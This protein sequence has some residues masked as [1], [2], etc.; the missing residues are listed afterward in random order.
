MSML[1]KEIGPKT[2]ISIDK[3]IDGFDWSNARENVSDAIDYH[4]GNDRYHVKVR[5]AEMFA[6]EIVKGEDEKGEPK[7]FQRRTKQ[8]Q[9]VAIENDLFEVVVRGISGKITGLIAS[10]AENSELKYTKNGAE[11][12]EAT[13]DIAAARQAAS[14][15]LKLSR[16]DEL[17]V[18]NGV[19]GMLIQ[20]SGANFR[21]EPIPADKI[22]IVFG[23]KIVEGEDLESDEYRAVN[24]LDIEDA[25]AVIIQLDDSDFVAYFGRSDEY[26]EGRMVKYSASEWHK[27]PSVG[28]DDDAE[29]YF[30]GDTVAN[31]LTVLQDE[32]GDYTTPEYPVVLWYG[33]QKGV[34]KEILPVSNRLYETSKEIDLTASRTMFA[35]N[36]GA[37][38]SWFYLNEAGAS[39]SQP[40]SFAEG[41]N[42][43]KSGQSAVVLTVPSGNIAEAESVNNNAASYFA[44]TY[45]VPTYMSGILQNVSIPSGAALME[46]NRPLNMTINKRYEINRSGMDKIWDIERSL[47]TIENG[48]D[49]YP[50]TEQTWNVEEVQIF[51]TANQKLTDAK[52]AKEL[53]I[54]DNAE[55][56]IDIDPT[57]ETRE[58]A[59]EKI[60][61]LVVAAP[62]PVANTTAQ[63]LGALGGLNGQ[64]P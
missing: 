64:Q 48:Q 22:F 8:A 62:A 37:R 47:A 3:L 35:A 60:S 51:E 43:L 23:N 42:V 20:V 32:T 18:L 11:D 28:E 4:D 19:C 15:G 7:E 55:I 39:P 59:E 45:G 58:Q 53:G 44:D 54:V 29:D 1:K 27:V 16:V 9:K 30:D 10:L 41:V 17:S 5:M 36:V 25:L 33:S 61:T 56:L 63:R 14:F 2:R 49:M 26:P 24:K 50:E 57:V 38:G 52:L 21:Y 34:G 40:Q 31:P 6:T 12:E 13:E 46:A